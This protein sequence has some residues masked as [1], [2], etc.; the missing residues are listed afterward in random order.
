MASI[1]Q[2]VT[3]GY[4]I[5]PTYADIVTRGYGISATSTDVVIYDGYGGGMVYRNKRVRAAKRS[6]GTS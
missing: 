3:R 5:S 1:A 6:F 2:I 4:Y